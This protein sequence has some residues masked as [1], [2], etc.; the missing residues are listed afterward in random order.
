[1][2]LARIAS[3]GPDGL[4]PRLVVVQPEQQ[5]VIDLVTAE[6]LR[7][8]R[9]GATHDAAL[10][11]ATALFPSSMTAAIALGDAFLIA[12]R[13]TVEQ[14]EEGAVIALSDVHLLPPL[15]PPLIRDFTAFEQHM[16]NM[17]ARLKQ[18]I[19]KQF[20]E[21]PLYYKGNA[22]TL[23]LHE[24][25]VPW[26]NYTEH[27]DYELE[28][29]FV[30]GKTGRNLAPQAAL[31]HLFGIGPWLVMGIIL[32]LFSFLGLLG[33]WI[34]AVVAGAAQIAG[35]AAW[36]AAPGHY[37]DRIN[38]ED[39]AIAEGLMLTVAGIGGFIIPVIFGIIAGTSGFTAAFIFGGIIGIVFALIGFAAREPKL[40]SATAQEPI[41]SLEKAF[42]PE[43][44]Q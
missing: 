25:E 4:I 13:H 10:R 21:M 16:H 35:F 12:T 24:Q 2:K 32:A 6:R 23:I 22:S 26:P 17:S 7:L 14:V 8:E 11:L 41:A 19:I 39:V 43:P 33:V 27:M 37:R 28:L 3:S 42:E 20:Y 29:G 34:M 1:M 31:S 40:V 36:T 9:Q 15:D 44:L 5:R 18:P 38:P 30:L